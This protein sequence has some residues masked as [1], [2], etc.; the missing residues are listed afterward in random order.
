MTKNSNDTKGEN[1]K[2]S[3]HKDKS[4]SHDADQL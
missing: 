1:H 2:E 4:L 3:T